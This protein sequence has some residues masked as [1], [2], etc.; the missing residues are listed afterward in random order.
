[1]RTALPPPTPFQTIQAVALG[2]LPRLFQARGWVLAALPLA[3]VA[4]AI[5]VTLLVQAQGG[6]V[7]P[8]EGLK[9]FH[10]GLVQVLLPIL[11]LSAAPVGIREDLEQR[12]LP[13]MLTRP[14][15]VWAYPFAK[16]LL[17][18]CWGAIWLVV[19]SLGLFVLGANAESVARGA[20][21]LVGVYWAELAFM[22]LLGLVFKRGTLWGALF[23]FLWDQFVRIMPGN[24]QRLTFRHYAESIAGSR[25]GEVGLRDLLAQT[26]LETPVWIAF[27]A[28]ILFGL[29][30]W[31]ACGWRLQTMPVGL[32]GK[33]A[34][35]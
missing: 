30:C 7:S 10:E 15:P 29:A 32:A 4:A 17:W 9:V 8:A 33:D 6:R 34:E 28:L 26:Q 5:V 12:T 2:Y 16:G 11:A 21:A 1:M 24:L 19:A 14:A 35:G 3:P 20:L 18:F 27:A 31:A 23:L 13:L 22:T 25:A